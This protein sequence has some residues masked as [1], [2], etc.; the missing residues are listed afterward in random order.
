MASSP[1]VQIAVARA[2]NRVK[3]SHDLT[4]V[5]SESGRPDNRDSKFELDG[6]NRFKYKPVIDFCLSADLFCALHALLANLPFK[7]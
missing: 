3:I 1:D 5:S 2:I 7:I 4:V 6:K